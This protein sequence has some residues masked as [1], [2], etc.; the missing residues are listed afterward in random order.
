MSFNKMLLNKYLYLTKDIKTSNTSTEVLKIK[1]E[2]HLLRLVKEDI[3]NNLVNAAT[4]KKSIE[5]FFQTV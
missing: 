2:V 1:N 3:D 5:T 4:L